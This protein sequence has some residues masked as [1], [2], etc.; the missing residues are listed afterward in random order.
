MATNIDVA[1]TIERQS[2]NSF[3]WMLMLW[4]SVTMV[5]EGFDNQV[6]GY[7]A[8]A[9]IK[10]WHLTKASFSEVFV[11]FQFGFMFGVAVFGLLGDMFGR[12]TMIVAGVILFGIFTAASAYT[13]DLNGLAATRFLAAVFL[14]GAVPNALALAIEYAPVAQRALRVTILYFCYS[15]GASVGGFLAAWMVPQYGWPS[16]Y[17]LGGVAA[18]ALVGGLYFML[19]ESARFMALRHKSRDKLAAVLRRLA[20]DVTIP[21]DAVF[22]VKNEAEKPASVGELFTEDRALKTIPL[23]AASLLSMVALQFTTSWLPTIFAD[24]NIGF[25]GASIALGFFQ[26]A[27]ATAGLFAGWMLDRPNGIQRLAF[28]ALCGAPVMVGLSMV[29][30]STNT[31]MLLTA[32]AGFCII[33]TQN[34]INALSGCLY[35]TAIRST[36]SGWTYGVGRIGAVLGPVLGGVLLGLKLPT[37]Q[38]LLI[39]A[40]PPACVGLALL[41]LHIFRPDA[42]T[43]T[44]RLMPG[45]RDNFAG[46]MGTKEAA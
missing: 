8:P 19:P 16:I 31:V 30:G 24:S 44:G 36:G 29:I 6:Q 20:P 10:A 21:A 38:I 4:M 22:V 42:V 18:L 3:Q 45:A 14:G 27:G 12:R 5:V 15:M 41:A 2:R 28:L 17:L 34:G 46:G 32:M 43:A 13:T 37:S 23:W 7:T 40:I 9:I 35:P 25:Q 33:G 11:S 26:A 39:I 1:E